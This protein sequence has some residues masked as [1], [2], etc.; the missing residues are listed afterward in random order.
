MSIVIAII[1]FCIIIL[2]HELGH[3]F[4]AKAFGMRVSEFA[5]GMGPT[6]LRKRGRETVYCL[7]LIP[8]GGS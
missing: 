5:I 6:L 8:M 3:F 4:V 2:I 7:K 1:A